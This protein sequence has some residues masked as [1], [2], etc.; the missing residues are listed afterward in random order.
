MKKSLN[1]QSMA[2]FALLLA[3]KIVL[4]R[5]TGIS[6][7]IVKL[8]FA[9]IA[10]AM[11][12]YLFGPWMSAVAGGLTDLMGFFLFPQ[13]SYFPG[14]TFTSIVAGFIYGFFL[15]NKKPSFMRIFL[16]VTL[17]AFICSLLLNT[18]WTSLL[19]GKAFFAILPARFI[20]NVLAIPL[21]SCM[22]YLIFKYLK[23]HLGSKFKP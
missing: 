9:F 19:Y 3:L 18:L 5:I 14:Y 17:Q 1:I 21:E 6:F 12:G 2:I 16:V 22:L 10:T 7:G 23:N 8:S 15:Y 13:G 20:K 11:T 4:S